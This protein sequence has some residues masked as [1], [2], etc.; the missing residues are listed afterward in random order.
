MQPPPRGDGH[1][2]ACFASSKMACSTA[3]LLPKTPSRR[4]ASA[5]QSRRSGSQTA[6]GTPRSSVPVCPT[7]SGAAKFCHLPR[8]CSTDQSWR[9]R[10]I[11]TA[12]QT[13]AC[14]PSASPA[15]LP[16]RQTTRH[17]RHQTCFRRGVPSFFGHTA[18]TATSEKEVVSHRSRRSR[19]CCRRY[20]SSEG[21]RCSLHER[22]TATQ[23]V[24]DDIKKKEE[25]EKSFEFLSQ[26]SFK[27]PQ[28]REREGREGF[29]PPFFA[30]NRWPRCRRRRRRRGC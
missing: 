15:A 20:S 26:D 25:R 10:N 13:H 3:L 22:W 29:A 7:R 6:S 18:V 23:E 17:H 27:K 16:S 11:G 2:P 1:A 12:F 24:T 4:N 21:A 19:S 30:P 8:C 9:W 28:L 14:R 5:C